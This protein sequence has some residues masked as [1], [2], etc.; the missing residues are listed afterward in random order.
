MNL[1]F[2]AGGV[3]WRK[4]LKHTQTLSTTKDSPL[5][6]Y[7]S[8]L[9][10]S[11]KHSAVSVYPPSQAPVVVQLLNSL[12]GLLW[13]FVVHTY[14]CSRSFTQR[15]RHVCRWIW[16]PFSNFLL[17]LNNKL[18]QK[19]CRPGSLWGF[20]FSLSTLS[21]TVYLFTS[22]TFLKSPPHTTEI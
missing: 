2:G 5:P 12:R 7:K 22:L 3:H 21:V 11:N 19:T 9:W 10:P 18:Q 15:K 1:K 13:V 6:P 14:F 16:K 4:I 17:W 20:H 8:P